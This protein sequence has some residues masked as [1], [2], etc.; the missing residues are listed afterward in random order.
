MDAEMSDGVHLSVK[1]EG[2]A[3]AGKGLVELKVDDAVFILRG[4]RS[5]ADGES[6][7]DGCCLRVEDDRGSGVL[8]GERE[9]ECVDAGDGVGQRS[10]FRIRHVCEEAER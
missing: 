9:G 10:R 5:L 4:Y 8:H 7:D 1:S 6:A 2:Q 3:V